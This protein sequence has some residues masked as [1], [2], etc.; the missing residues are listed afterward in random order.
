MLEKEIVKEGYKKTDIGIIP[1]D[2][3]CI[4]MGDIGESIIGLTY[5]PE[6]IKQYGKLVLRSSNINDNKLTFDDNVFVDIDVKD[7]LI[8]KENDLLICVRNGSR[9]LIGKCALINKEAR[10][11]TFGAFMSLYRSEKSKYIFHYFQTNIIKKQINENIGATINQIT[12]KN[13][14]SFLVAIPQNKKEEDSI[15]TA[16][17]N[18]DNLLHLIVKLID[19]K[20]KIKQGIMQQLLTG[21]I[22]LPGFSS[23]WVNIQLTELVDFFNGKAH[24]NSISVRGKYVVVNSKF[25]SSEGQV[26]KL[27]NDAH[28]LA[29]KDDI[30]MVMSD[31]P[32]GK[33]I[34]KCFYVDEDNKYTVN[35]RIC[36]LRS[37]IAYPRF[38]YYIIDRNP[39][40]LTFDDGVKQTNLR[41]EDVL[42]C[43]IKIPKNYEEQKAIANVLL[44]ID[45]EIEALEQ[46][47]EKYKA[48]KQ[49]MM[50]ELLT[51]RVRLL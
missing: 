15:V 21:K 18:I 39:Y 9:K 38:L 25:I 13:L 16:L 17:S 30:L 28:C 14:N 27:S 23:K 5:K 10:G 33:A 6:N 41:K 3:D 48:I 22:R 34:A 37:R 19:K 4:K 45:S 40:Y 47:L 32:N 46:K 7:K 36:I 50:Q 51:G 31:V 29:S 8:I 26:V 49:G 1:E 35:Q 12:N 24:E 11:A 42:N 43:E 44:D 2:W 20:K